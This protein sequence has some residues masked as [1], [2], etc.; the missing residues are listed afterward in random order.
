MPNYNID[1]GFFIVESLLGSYLLYLGRICLID[2]GGFSV[3]C[4]LVMVMDRMVRQDGDLVPWRAFRGG[5][6]PKC[7]SD[8]AF[9]GYLRGL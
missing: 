5:C 4:D 8:C 2:S 3:S 9:L 1:P 7:R 6:A